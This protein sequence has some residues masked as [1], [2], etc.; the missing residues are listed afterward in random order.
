M[1]YRYLPSVALAL[2]LSVVLVS[3][4]LAQ[5]SGQQTR[6]TSY[7]VVV[8]VGPPA[9]PMRM[10]EP[11]IEMPAPAAVPTEDMA[12]PDD[13]D[14]LGFD[15]DLDEESLAAAQD[16]E[17]MPPAMEMPTPPAATPPA[18]ITIPMMVPVLD[19]GQ[20]V[21]RRLHINVADAVLGAL[22]ADQI[23]VIHVDLINR[24]SGETRRLNDMTPNNDVLS[25][26]ME[27]NFGT[28]L[29]LPEGVYEMRVHVN[30]QTALFPSLVVPNNDAVAPAR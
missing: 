7:V 2:L 25:G 22:S 5:R 21:N 12:T 13:Q 10:A 18:A 4:G 16:E 15:E 23:P 27:W 11:S 19:Q 29:F 28:D 3:P 8:Q 17:E 9:S 30:G 1:N 26:P 6:T 24:M 14:S 20:A